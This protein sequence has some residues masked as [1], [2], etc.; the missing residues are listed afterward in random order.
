MTQLIMDTLNRTSAGILQHIIHR[1]KTMTKPTNYT[2]QSA[3]LITHTNTIHSSSCRD[4]L[5]RLINLEDEDT[6]TLLDVRHY[7]PN[8]TG[9]HA[10]DL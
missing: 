5:L 10:R 9:S 8:E 6:M 3:T 1:E 2:H 7:L 4:I